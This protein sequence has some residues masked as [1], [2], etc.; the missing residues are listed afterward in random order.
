MN[1]QEWHPI[2]AVGGER[3]CEQGLSP[4]DGTELSDMRRNAQFG[5]VRC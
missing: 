4:A 1:W 5:I 3:R 2:A